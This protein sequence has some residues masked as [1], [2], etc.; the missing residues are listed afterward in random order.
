LQGGYFVEIGGVS[1]IVDLIEPLTVLL[2]LPVDELSFLDGDHL[3]ID[4]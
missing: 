1:S 4:G 2:L 3:D